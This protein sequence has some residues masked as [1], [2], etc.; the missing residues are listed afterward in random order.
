MATVH[1]TRHLNE[2]FPDLETRDIVATTVAELVR[3]LDMHW[4][5]L[6]YYIVDEQGRLRKHVALW[7]DGELVGDR[8]QLSDALH[9]DATVHILQALSGG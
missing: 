7:V 6:T 8:E 5:G 1:F 2:F 9:P 4:P 3:A